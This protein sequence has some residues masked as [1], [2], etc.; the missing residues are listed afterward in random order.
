MPADHDPYHI[1]RLT[2]THDPLFG[3]IRDDPVRPHLDPGW[4]VSDPGCAVF[5]LMESSSV[6]AMVCMASRESVP[7]DEEELLAGSVGTVAVFYTIWSYSPGGGRRLIR[8]LRPWL[9]EHGD[10][11]YTKFVTL[12]PKTEMARKFHIN[13]GAQE[14]R[15]NADTVNY[16]YA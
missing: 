4:R 5:A 2:G 9:E 15:M 11:G 12:S 10:I 7:R 13:N 16:E 14:M 8:Q 1:H 6:L 3:L